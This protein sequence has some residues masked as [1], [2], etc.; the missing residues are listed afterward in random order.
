MYL[1]HG[2]CDLCNKHTITEHPP[3]ANQP[4]Y[5]RE[6]WHGDSWDP[7]DYGK[8]FDFSRPFFDQLKELKRTCPAQA[9]SI[10]GTNENSEYIH[11]A[12]FSKNS[13]L[14]MHSDHCE[15][16][17]YG[18]GFK[19]VKNCVDG[20]YNV[21][22]ELCFDCID[23]TY[24]YGLI[25]CQDC[26]NTSASAFLRDCIGC[27]NCFLCTGLR[28]K[29]YCFENN[30]LTKEEYQKKIDEIDL[31]SYDQYLKCR[32]KRRDLEK[33][34]TFKYVMG[35]KY[36]NSLGF[37]LYNCKNV[38]ESFDIDDVEDGKFLYQIVLG[39]KDL[40]DAYQYGNNFQVSYENSICGQSSYNLL[41]C[42]ET[43]WAQN[44]IYGWYIEHCKY[45][46][47]CANM[48]HKKFCI[49]N[50]QF[51]EDEYNELASKIIEYMQTTKE[52]GEFIP[53]THI[54]HGYNKTTA[55]LHYPLSK[56]EVLAKNIPW[57]DYEPP[58][59]DNTKIIDATQLPDN[60]DD[61]PDDVLNWAIKCEVSG[62]LFKITPQ[63]LRFY[64]DRKLPLP[65]K[66]WEERHMARF[67]E[68]NPSRLWNRKCDKCGMNIR[69][70]Y[71]PER[72]E[73]VYCETCYH[74][75]VYG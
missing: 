11:L 60:L 39:A 17:Y 1:Y 45:C 10:Q 20:Y 21:N 63:E 74:K 33:T 46:L 70:S 7:R 57:D 40:Y 19:R 18:Y 62:K 47:G 42:H 13:Y 56:E 75:E 6:C 72:P 67:K 25:G 14:I 30:Q 15:N 41:F 27:K 55:Q 66:C 22:S 31:K 50:K 29:E 8:D 3:H 34:H 44:V 53:L 37:Q 4:I 69:T 28:N 49:L 64:R 16:C 59:P 38:H 35:Y 48:H 61:I 52:W 71:S 65:R 58:P 51:S 9:L 32:A 24:C 54:L 68:R 23:V 26:V 2:A 5:C 73:I 36:E 43:H 12:G